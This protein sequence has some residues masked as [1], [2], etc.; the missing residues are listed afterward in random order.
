MCSKFDENYKLVLYI[1]EALWW[2]PTENAVQMWRLM[3]PYTHIHAHTHTRYEKA[4]YSH[5]EASLEIKAAF[6]S[7]SDNG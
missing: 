7:W 2:T 6:P 1:L 4:Y 3:M 5:N